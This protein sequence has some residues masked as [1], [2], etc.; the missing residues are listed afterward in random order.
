M[1]RCFVAGELFE[2]ESLDFPILWFRS[3]KVDFFEADALVPG[4]SQDKEFLPCVMRAELCSV[5]ELP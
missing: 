3:Y 5:D 4:L 2:N 1:W